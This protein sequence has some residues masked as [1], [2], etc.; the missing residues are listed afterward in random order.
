MKKRVGFDLNGWYDLADRNWQITPGEGIEFGGPFEF[1][2]GLGGA[3]VKI[4]ENGRDQRFLGGIQASIAPHGRGP[5]WGKVG[6]DR[7]HSQVVTLLERPE[8][9][10]DALAAS[11]SAL[12]PGGKF[13]GILSIDDT[14][15]MRET[16]QEAL[17]EALRRGGAQRGLLV[18]KPVLALLGALNIDQVAKAEKIGVVCHCAQ[19]FSSQVLE[20]RKD[21]IATP[22]RQQAGQLHPSSLGLQSLLIRAH[23]VV[24]SAL[25]D[26]QNRVQLQAAQSPWRLALGETSQTEVL[27]EK[28]ADWDLLTPPEAPALPNEA[29][30]DSI[31]EHLST[32]DLVLF[33][34]PATGQVAQEIQEWM[35]KILISAPVQVLP[36]N[37]IALGALEAAR[38]LQKNQPIYFDFLPQI[39]TIVQDRDGAR[40][41]DLIP[42]NARLR[43]GETYRSRKPARFVLQ[44]GTRSLSV[45][46]KKENVPYA[47]K[48]TIG[49][50]TPPRENIGIA[51]S[52][53]QKPASGRARLT[54]TSEGLSAPLIVDWEGAEERIE[55][56]DTIIESQKPTLPTVPSRLVLPCGLEN[57]ED[58]EYTQGLTRMLERNL[59]YRITDWK[60]LA[61]KLS[62]RPDGKY[63]VSSKGN[64][65]NGLRKESKSDLDK[66]VQRAETEIRE[67][68]QGKDSM[69]NDAL[70][71]LTWLFHYCPQW[72]VGPMIEAV[73]S[74]NTS[75]PFRVNS[76]AT[77]L[78]LQGIGRTAS[79]P[80]DQ[81]HAFDFLLSVP[82]K[83]WNKNHLACAAFILSRNDNA[84]A[85]L[86]RKDV[87]FMAGVAASTMQQSLGSQYTS[88][89]IYAPFLLVGLLRW[90]LKVPYA[91]VAGT[92]RVADEL[93]TITEQVIEDL[94]HRI[95]AQSQLAKYQKVLRDVV[96]ELKGQGT[97]P[98]L[99]L[100]LETLT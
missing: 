33:H 3:V 92:D 72:I 47:R 40:N 63:A 83:T 22:E 5:G 99:L 9:N 50:P 94:G 98:N 4:D 100:D 58:Q 48:A 26:Q 39:S 59:I 7:R 76:A 57:W 32:C 91:L 41:E 19:G 35:K 12:A 77:T 84:P 81:K 82:P 56:W 10:V 15:D 51:L 6:E 80:D 53:E 30:P 45:F 69:D 89:F 87:E 96:E 66:I 71:F 95:G 90:R 34:S 20:L 67:R 28:N 61:D 74:A 75:H 31:A 79:N 18:W 13:T 65:P 88:T 46:L 24:K 38:R 8:D 68:L 86:T 60:E 27:R 25:G 73:V 62:A 16:A 97:N 21:D 70:R 23:D 14:P 44:Q 36:R 37:V 64:L 1:F 85:L 93:L 17:L 11:L 42:D 54:L 2:G 29:P 43:A 52:V 78:L 55:A 49:L